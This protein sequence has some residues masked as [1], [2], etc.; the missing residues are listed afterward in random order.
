MDKRNNVEIVF[1]ELKDKGLIDKDI[2]L[3]RRKSVPTFKMCF[4]K[5]KYNPQ[6]SNL[7]KQALRFILLHEMGHKKMVPFGCPLF[8]TLI[9]SGTVIIILFFLHLLEIEEPVIPFIIFLIFLVVCIAA[10]RRDEFRADK[11]AAEKYSETY[12]KSS[13]KAIKRA[14]EELNQIPLGFSKK[15]QRIILHPS[16]E[17]RYKAILEFEKEFRKDA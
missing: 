4:N 12:K 2:K 11:W 9:T 3:E 5:I 13:S 14:L 7:S 15:I 16:D 6:H 8:I 17:K 10:A 1:E